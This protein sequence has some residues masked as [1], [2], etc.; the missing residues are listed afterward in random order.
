MEH[1]V[2]SENSEEL[3]RGYRVGGVGWEFARDPGKKW[4]GNSGENIRY[5]VERVKKRIIFLKIEFSNHFYSVFDSFRFPFAQSR[6]V[7]TD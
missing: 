3:R 1:S 6:C 7:Q 4:M 5:C 2:V